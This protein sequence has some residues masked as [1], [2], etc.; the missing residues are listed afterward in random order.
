MPPDLR[1]GPEEYLERLGRIVDAVDVP[2]IASLNG[3]HGGHWLDWAVHIERAGAKA[4]ELNLYHVPSDPKETG[5]QIED[6]FVAMVEALAAKVEIP[7]AVKLT[8]FFTSLASFAPRLVDAGAS[9]LVLFNRSYQSD[10]DVE[11]L[12]AART[13][14]LSDPSTLLLRLRWLAILSSQVEA[15]LAVTGGVHDAPGAVK[16][17]MAGASAIQVV[18]MLL[19]QGPGALEGL[20]RDFEQWLVE[21]EYESLAQ[22]R[23]SMNLARAPDP[24]AYLRGNYIRILQSW[25]GP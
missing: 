14:T 10:I 20:R 24:Q 16:S 8:P 9:G 2:V 5:S 15:P 18:S 17:I 13:L 3:I 6:R 7:V 23:G 19:R 1:L 4:I 22:M 25:N 12:E 21:H 11:A